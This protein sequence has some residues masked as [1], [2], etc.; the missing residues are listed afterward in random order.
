MTNWATQSEHSMRSR[1]DLLQHS[2]RKSPEKR[3]R[4]H[5]QRDTRL[6]RSA[7]SSNRMRFP[8]GWQV[9]VVRPNG[10][11][12]YADLSHGSEYYVVG[13]P[14]QPFEVRVTVPSHIFVRAPHVRVVL[15]LDG[16][17][18]FTRH[19][20]SACSPSARFKGFVN[21]V[22]GQHIRS[23]FIFGKAQSDSAP[24]GKLGKSSIGRVTIRL[25]QVYQAPELL[26][27]T[28]HV[29]AKSAQCFKAD[30]GTN[31]FT[32]SLYCSV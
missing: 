20:V 10:G 29:S 19:T 17:E 7:V 23:Q 2:A 22:S 24:A 6:L 26:G 28:Y 12:Y 4:E 8:A 30:E 3:L 5:L 14:D 31:R 11:Q 21:T 27:P 25:E 13:I 16:L 9:N 18:Q 1:S 15:T 32:R